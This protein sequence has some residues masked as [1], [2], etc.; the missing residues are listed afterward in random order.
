MVKCVTRSVPSQGDDPITEGVAA[1]DPAQV[2]LEDQRAQQ[3]IGGGQVLPGR[4]GQ[5]LRRD[6]T[7]ARAHCLHQAQRTLDGCDERRTVG[8]G[9]N[10][11]LER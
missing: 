8:H 4:R 9:G 3:V 1:V 7:V 11:L 6:R 2:A 10:L 5:R